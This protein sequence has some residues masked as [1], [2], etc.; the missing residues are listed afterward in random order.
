[1]QYKVF[2]THENYLPLPPKSYKSITREKDESADAFVLRAREYMIN[3]KEGEVFIESL[4]ELFGGDGMILKQFGVQSTYDTILDGPSGN[5][6]LRKFN[7]V[8]P[9]LDEL[10]KD[11]FEHIQNGWNDFVEWNDREVKGS[12]LEDV[13]IF[14]N[15]PVSTSCER[16]SMLANSKKEG[17]FIIFIR[18]KPVAAGRVSADNPFTDNYLRDLNPPLLAYNNPLLSSDKQAKIIKGMEKVVACAEY[19]LPRIEPHGTYIKQLSAGATFEF[20]KGALTQQE[21]AFYQSRQNLEDY[22]K[23]LEE[24]L[25]N[26]SISINVRCFH[27][28][29]F[30]YYYYNYYY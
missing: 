16:R 14:S 27:C 1:M 18:P 30:D 25:H 9:K 17:G 24:V 12:Q 6:N 28:C 5:D 11:V 22:K 8:V 3:T 26:Y 23:V 20:A 10:C 4:R 29:M 7:R 2:S 21:I 15:L 13:E 19:W